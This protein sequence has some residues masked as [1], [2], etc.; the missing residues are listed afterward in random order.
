MTDT[1]M[2]RVIK[3]WSTADS[4][5]YNTKIGFTEDLGH[6]SISI[7]TNITNQDI[8]GPMK[9]RKRIKRKG[10]AEKREKA[11]IEDEKKQASR[12]LGDMERYL[13]AGSKLAASSGLARGKRPE[14]RRQDN[15]QTAQHSNLIDSADILN[16]F[17]LEENDDE[18]D[19]PKPKRLPPKPVPMKARTGGKNAIPMARTKPDSTALRRLAEPSRPEIPL[20]DS[21][22]NDIGPSID[23]LDTYDVKQPEEEEEEEEMNLAPVAKTRTSAPV[24]KILRSLPQPSPVFPAPLAVDTASNEGDW[25]KVQASGETIEESGGVADVNDTKML[26]FW[27]DAWEK[28]GQIYLFGKVSTLF[29]I[30]RQ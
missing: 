18:E 11:R 22:L 25:F 1:L 19:L 15:A 10:D 24:R 6:A 4:Y 23:D 26:F 30:D 7:S 16:S 17:T 28:D 14:V 5:T 8:N 3:R 21:L 9:G 29:L 20:D 27:L 13:T 12:Q 2:E